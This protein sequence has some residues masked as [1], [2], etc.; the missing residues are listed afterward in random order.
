MVTP[1]ELTPH[2][3]RGHFVRFPRLDSIRNRIIAFAVVATLI[4]S[5]ITLAISYQQN[6]RA[7]EARITQ[8]LVS[9][10]EQTAR[11][12]SVWLKE[13]LYDLRFF[14]ASDEVAN[15]LGG[16]AAPAAGGRTP[17]APSSPTR[18][19][20]REYLVSLNERLA[21]YGQLMVLDANG[22]VVGTTR[23]N[24]ARVNLPA[25]W[26][27]TLRVEDQLV[28]PPDW[29][30]VAKTGKI[31]VAVPVKRADGR[32]IGAFAAELNLSP[33]VGLIRSF[34]PDTSGAIY[35]VNGAGN[36]VASS[37]G[38]SPQVLN[39]RVRDTTLA[40]LV[41]E[42]RSSSRYLSAG[43]VEV[44]GTAEQVPQV[45][46]VV[47]SEIPSEA[48]F[49]QLSR[50]RNLSIL[51]VLGLLIAVAASAYWLGVII[52][53]PLDRLTKG[54]AEVAAGDLA[55]DLPQGGGGEVGYLTNVFNYMVS[56]L[57]EGRR[58]LDSI[59]ETLQKKN[60]EL[61]MLSITDGLTGLV[62]HR[63][64]IQKLNEEG[65]RASRYK[66]E[67]SVLMADVDHFKQYND[68][69]GHPA[70]DEV[71]RRVADII[72]ASVRPGDTAARYG[73]E[74]FAIVMPETPGPEAFEIAEHIRARVASEAFPG[75]K[76]TL[77]IGVAEFPSDADLPHAVIAAADKALYDAKRDGRNRTVEAN[78]KRVKTN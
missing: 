69:F 45:D 63:F 15:S 9:Q 64:L 16:G 58:E 37:E 72:R 18:N 31:L 77:S 56:R 29:N 11:S 20:L 65:I 49:R 21:D 55:V 71:L 74:E 26:L 42:S 76:I 48:A 46:W 30:S 19:R 43:D 68:E 5:G 60:E 22:R 27:N 4:P 47:I 36:L 28:G 39:T 6:R 23:G 14:A 25:R 12:L 24:A 10:S 8:D 1:A 57:R 62:N 32:L 59:N 70:G 53:R 38:I 44:I 2:R 7:L 61:E 40:P 34:A 35:V 66:H 73:G 52:A 41:A 3:E 50:F 75:K 78:R 13:R 54:A 17:G 67:F 33:V 51:V